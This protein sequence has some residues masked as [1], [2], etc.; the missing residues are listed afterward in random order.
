MGS[1]PPLFPR[2]V[3]WCVV[4]FKPCRRFASPALLDADMRFSRAIVPGLLLAVV[5]GSGSNPGRLPS[6]PAAEPPAGKPVPPPK[7][8][9]AAAFVKQ[10]CVSCHNAQKPKADLNLA[11]FTDS[12]SVLKAR[13]KWEQVVL[14]VKSGEMPPPQKPKPSQADRDA[15]LA[16]VE[17]IFDHADR[18]AKP[19]PGR[20]TMRRLNRAEYN[21]TIRDLIG[22]DFNPADDFPSD[23]VG[24]GFDNIGDVLT[25][26]PVLMERYLGAAENIM[27]RAIF[28]NP[29]KPVGRW[30]SA[31]YTEP[32]SA[33]VPMKDRFRAISV[34]GD[35]V[36]TG[37]VHTPYKVPVDGEYIFR[38]QVYAE[39]T[40]KEPVK[41][42]ILALCDKSAPGLASDKDIE[43]LVGNAAGMKPF[44]ILQTVEVK[45]R[46]P[47]KANH[48]EVKVPPNLGLHRM[49][50]A[51][52]KPS[53]DEPDPKLYVHHLALEG[54]LDTR[55][56]SQRRLLACDPKKPQ[57][58]QT[59]EVMAR[60]ASK[61]YRR[62]AT[63]DE[64]ERLA[65][66][67]DAAL[68]RGEKWEA[69]CQTAFVAALVSPKF[70]FRVELD[71]RPD[72]PDAHPIDEYQLASRL[73]YFLWSSMPDDE[74]VALAGK[75]QLSANLP[76]QVKRMLRDP[77]ANALVDNFVM[78][79][80]QLQPLSKVQPDTK[81]FPGFNEQLRTAMRTETELFFEELIREDR[82]V[83]E[84]LD[85]DFTYLNRQLAQHYGIQDTAGNTA[86][87]KPRKPGGK[88]IPNEKF[89]R[90]N[91]AGTGRGGLLLQASVL[92]V[93]SNPTRTSPVKRGKWVL[94]QLLGTPPP[95]PPPN[96][97]E[98]EK[99]GKPLSAG[100][101]RQRMEEHRKN[102][103][104]ANCHAKMDPLGFGLENF[105]AVGGFRAKDPDAN[106]APIDPS[107]I[108]PDGKT[109]AGP[110]ELKQ[111]LLAKKDLF[112]RC[113]AERMLTY[114]IGRG[115]EPTDKRHVDRIVE[116]TAK[117]G[118][119]FS[120][121]V[122]AVVTSD[123]FRLRRGK[124]QP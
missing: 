7:F 46:D 58:E 116:L 111:I 34:K 72:S 83:L 107:G 16:T 67:V 81:R 9:V 61:A 77:K 11:S 89:V 106:W 74:L 15:F 119:K 47:K 1:L 56:A 5:V 78:Q 86:A 93:T 57:A 55:P 38:T 76:A 82:S 27:E 24:H 32:A 19:D 65:K 40:G 98:L 79:W 64:V 95:P 42:A 45:S 14:A 2:G 54:P 122:T 108:L 123:P 73:S 117:D 35:G 120:A 102:V 59:R 94:E 66:I 23:D 118:F 18:N 71:D 110:H 84:I 114:A 10:H 85:A 20:V 21:A 69:G 105:D 25:L 115:L 8:D 91:L 36:Q 49:A 80:L 104:C 44:V 97:P 13:K 22:I 26:S 88:Q 75:K 92:T 41:M 62:P 87:T 12:A 112:L 4:Y 43:Q 37:P 103:A 109:F 63:A 51:L 28:P 52:V 30:Q 68:A 124:S 39:T 53:K 100:T 96:V 70:L 50:V 48:F 3:P 33:N 17:G 121:L 29:P 99:D 113:L 90:V 101:L 60:F 6:A 31:Q